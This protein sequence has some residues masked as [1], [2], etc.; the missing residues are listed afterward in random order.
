MSADNFLV[1]REQPDGTFKVLEG[2]LSG[3]N[4]YLAAMTITEG[5]LYDKNASCTRYAFLVRGRTPQ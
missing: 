4:D 5:I 3:W 1:I 2:R